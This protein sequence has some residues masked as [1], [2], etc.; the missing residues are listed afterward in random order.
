MLFHERSQEHGYKIGC[1][2]RDNAH[3][4]CSPQIGFPEV[5]QIC[6][7]FRLFQYDLC[8]INNLSSDI[9]WN[10]RG[11]CAVENGYA[12]FVFQFV[13]L[14]AKSG[15]GDKTFFSRGR[16]MAVFINSDNVGQLSEGHRT[17]IKLIRL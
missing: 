7:L 6:N 15:L 9:C 16:K 4:K 10:Y 2:C 11:F 17:G 5:C 14:Y 1:N 3:L 12:K 8:L 13:D